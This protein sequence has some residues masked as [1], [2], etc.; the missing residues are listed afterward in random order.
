[1]VVR[2]P[3]P[4]ARATPAG[5][6]WASLWGKPVFLTTAVGAGTALVGSFGGAARLVRRGG[7]TVEATN[8]HDDHFLKNL[9]AIRAETREALC[10]FRPAAFTAVSGLTS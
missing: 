10:V 4:T 2:S 3:A 7:V 9:T 8:S 5:L 6:F 1:V